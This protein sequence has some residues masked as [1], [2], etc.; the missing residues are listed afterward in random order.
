MKP[1][2]IDIT[3]PKDYEELVAEMDFGDQFRFIF[4]QEPGEAEVS[5]SIFNIKASD[6]DATQAAYTKKD[7]S[8]MIPVS[9][10][11]RLLDQGVEALLSLPKK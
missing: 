7:K 2:T 6:Y 3:S 1:I 5:V 11:R 9:V 8:R 4:S 10:L